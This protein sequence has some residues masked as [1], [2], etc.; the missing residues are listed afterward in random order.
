MQQYDYLITTHGHDARIHPSF[1]GG[2]LQWRPCVGPRF[3]FVPDEQRWWPANLELRV[4]ELL[5]SFIIAVF[6]R[7]KDA[8]TRHDLGTSLGQP[9]RPRDR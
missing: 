1:G 6:N 3:S 9:Y 8:G 7:A 2:R 4:A 5:E